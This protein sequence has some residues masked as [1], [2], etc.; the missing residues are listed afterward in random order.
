M[1]IL[2]LLYVITFEIDKRLKFMLES[3]ETRKKQDVLIK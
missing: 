2:R 3:K 1:Q